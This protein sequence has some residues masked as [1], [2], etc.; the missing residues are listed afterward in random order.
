MSA[1][2]KTLTARRNH[3]TANRFACILAGKK[4][5]ASRR[6]ASQPVPLVFRNQG[7]FLRNY[8]ICSEAVFSRPWRPLEPC[9]AAS[10]CTSW[11]QSPRALEGTCRACDSRCR[12][13]NF[14]PASSCCSR[15][16]AWTNLLVNDAGPCDPAL[17]GIA[18]RRDGQ[19][20]IRPAGSLRPRTQKY[21]I[22][23]PQREQTRAMLRRMNE[24]SGSRFFCEFDRL[25]KEIKSAKGLPSHDD[26]ITDNVQKNPASDHRS[27]K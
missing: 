26:R 2:A 17:R 9:Q 7:R 20:S 11:R 10:D 8:G 19:E 24:C 18:I 13:R 21:A 22:P 3:P 4:R 25:A 6:T 14:V 23:E 1:L 16:P 12:T 27:A 15:R 5:V